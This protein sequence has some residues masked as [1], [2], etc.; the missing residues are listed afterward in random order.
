MT[1]L[2]QMLD[3]QNSMLLASAG[4]LGVL[5]Y[6]LLFRRYLRLLGE[7]K[8]E[9]SRLKYILDGTN[10]GTWEWNVQTGETVF[11][12][13][14]AEIIG[15]SL[16]DLGPVSI[17]TWMKYAHPDD[18]ANSG[19]KLQA[20]FDGLAEF[21]DVEARMKHKEGHWVWVLD[22]GKVATWTPDGRPEWM[23]GT[24]QDIS[25]TKTLQDEL[26][27]KT[28]DAER[29]A[30]MKSEFLAVMSH[31]IRT[32]MNGVLGLIRLARDAEDVA[33]K[34]DYLDGAIES[35]RLLLNVVNDILDYS[36]IEAGKVELVSAPCELRPL[37][38]QLYQLF[39]NQANEKGLS[40][41]VGCSAELPAFVMGDG[42]R[43][44]QVLNN[45]IG[46]AIKFT[47]QGAVNLDAFI[48]NDRLC[49]SIKDSGIGI[50]EEDLGKLFQPFSQVASHL[51][52][53]VTGSG[54]GL[55]ICKQLINQ[56]GGD[57]E[58]QSEPHKGST[59]TV[60]L[61]VLP[62]DT[63]EPGFTQPLSATLPE[64]LGQL[65]GKHVLLA[66]DHR[67][68]IMVIGANLNKLGVT[69]D[70]AGNGREAIGLL[71][72]SCKADGK[73]YDLILMDIQMPVMN[74]L[75]AT[76]HM[77][78]M[79]VPQMPPIVALT[80]AASDFEREQYKA[81]GMHDF[82][83]KPLDVQQ[84]LRVLIQCTVESDPVRRAQPGT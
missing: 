34:N 12:A 63:G 57:I 53:T 16:K 54:L 2:I 77:L 82:L 36:K 18:L 76:R 66:E 33:T 62:C 73:P 24:H 5:L 14:W 26:T 61:P 9:K 75:D 51:N 31:E 3:R 45:L 6:W 28:L 69:Y 70:V 42:V 27:R 17:D 22:R 8:R 74:G 29:A 65:K 19:V 7:I 68:N 59:F 32:P 78:S 81:A 1:D 23:Y 46:N 79:K 40:L 37:L 10:V 25:A 4:V 43:L 44:S 56:M 20:H 13:R 71:E 64:R 39:I 35:G 55:V 30:S 15:Y 58:V 47:H 48:E 72:N 84:L 41:N 21:Y 38:K 67:L 49:F 83:S 60:S 50:E 11:N 80:A 52:R